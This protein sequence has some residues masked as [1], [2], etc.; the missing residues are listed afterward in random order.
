MSIKRRAIAAAGDSGYNAIG[1][2]LTDSIVEHIRN[3]E[4][5][6]RVHGN[7]ADCIAP[8]DLVVRNRQRKSEV[9]VYRRPTVAGVPVMTVSR[10]TREH[11]RWIEFENDTW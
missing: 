4:I 7:T 6:C 3:V 10:H 11:A 5:A 8:V 1:C 9:R 2:Y